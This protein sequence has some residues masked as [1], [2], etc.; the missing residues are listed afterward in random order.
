MDEVFAGR[1]DELTR[2]ASL[3]SDM[4]DGRPVRTRRWR[5]G[6]GSSEDP[7][8]TGP[9]RVVLVHGLGG[10][11]KSR[12]LRHFRDMA[13]GRVP[14]FPVPQGRVRTAWLDWEDEQQRE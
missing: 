11:G 10:S 13:Q 4:P 9:S 12:L 2:F 6:R 7:A 5:R 1:R 3:L 8:T 14:G